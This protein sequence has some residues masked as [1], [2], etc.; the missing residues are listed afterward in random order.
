MSS[1]YLC[2]VKSVYT[3]F[4]RQLII[5]SAILSFIAVGLALMV[6]K[7]FITPV[8]P[9]LF[10]FFLA[11]TL[12]SYYILVKASQKKFLRFL[13]YYLLTTAAKLILF[14]AVLVAYIM[15]NKSDAVPFALSFFILYLCY[16]IFE[17][18]SIVRYSRT[19]QQ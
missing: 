11:T 16:T 7:G 3:T 15:L 13:N 19:I 14:I 8:L 1:V 5:F 4:L 10:I 17:V 12:L 18:V 6:P 2:P 9:L